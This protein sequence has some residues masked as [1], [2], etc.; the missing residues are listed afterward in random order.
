ML[1]SSIFSHILIMSL[2][3]YKIFL[4][5]YAKLIS[6]T[7]VFIVFLQIPA[8]LPSYILSWICIHISNFNWI[9]SSKSLKNGGNFSI[10]TVKSLISTVCMS[11]C[12]AKF[13]CMMIRRLRK[14]CTMKREKISKI[15][16][17]MAIHAFSILKS[18][19]ARVTS[20]ISHS[21]ITINY[22]SSTSDSFL[23]WYGKPSRSL[24]LEDSNVWVDLCSIVSTHP[25]FI[26]V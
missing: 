9:S 23:Y 5:L 20:L 3:V 13:F 14:I 7:L 15:T 25:C 1:Y 2:N 4:F 11:N 18:V 6:T 8:F 12:F 10:L 19:P 21:D 26:L 17:M 16:I 22:G 24:K